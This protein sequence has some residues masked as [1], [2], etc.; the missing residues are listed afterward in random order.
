M[1]AAEAQ[2]EGAGDAGVTGRTFL[3]SITFWWG[4][5]ISSFVPLQAHEAEPPCRNLLQRFSGFES[6]GAAQVVKGKIST[7]I[8]SNSSFLTGSSTGI[9]Y[10]RDF[11]VREGDLDLP[12]YIDFSFFPENFLGSMRLPRIIFLPG[13]KDLIHVLHFHLNRD[14]GDGLEDLSLLEDALSYLYARSEID[15]Q[16]HFAI[17][18]AALV[19]QLNEILR[20]ALAEAGWEG[21]APHL[22]TQKNEQ[23]QGCRTKCFED[24]FILGLTRESFIGWMDRSDADEVQERMILAARKSIFVQKILA[25]GQWN[26]SINIQSVDV[27]VEKGKLSGPAVAYKFVGVLRPAW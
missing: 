16:F 26:F 9:V 5:G 10:L 21:D 3:L 27:H 4:A 8:K 14:L 15:D 24:S 11:Q 1:R 25:S 20:E 2:R 22:I 6:L 7:D 13:D 12:F 23:I 19:R 18:E 17:S